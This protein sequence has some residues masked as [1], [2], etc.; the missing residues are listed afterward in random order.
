MLV[1]ADPFEVAAFALPQGLDDARQQAAYDHWKSSGRVVAGSF[2]MTLIPLLV[3][4][5]SGAFAHR[6]LP[7][8]V[9]AA[10]LRV[11]GVASSLLLGS[12]VG[13]RAI[14]RAL[15]TGESSDIQT[16]LAMLAIEAL[17]IALA[18]PLSSM[19]IRR[20]CFTGI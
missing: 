14:D 9:P 16:P 6:S 4:G 15:S 13:A 1:R 3:S 5:L 7:S 10:L 19:A 8:S 20:R 2:A 18:A 17:C 12:T 11:M